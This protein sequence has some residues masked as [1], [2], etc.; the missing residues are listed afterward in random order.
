MTDTPEDV[1]TPADD[2]TVG[3]PDTPGTPT[4]ASGP[5]LSLGEAVRTTGAARSTLQRRLNAGQIPGATRTPGGGWSIPIRGLIAAGMAPKVTPPDKTPD[6]P[7]DE[8]V[9]DLEARME[10]ALRNAERYRLEAEAARELA[11]E[12]GRHVEDLREALYALSRALP[13][14][15]DEAVTPASNGSVNTAPATPTTQPAA[16]SVTPSAP[17]RRRRFFSR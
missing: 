5:V 3:T 7:T 10:D 6:R 9:A 11:E 13:P 1:P 8:V 12:R 2:T 16:L 4:G 15:P 14:G 17:P